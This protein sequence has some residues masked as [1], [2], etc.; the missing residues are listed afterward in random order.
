MTATKHMKNDR[1]SRWLFI[2]ETIGVGEVIRSTAPYLHERTKQ[3]CY[4]ELTS[5]G[6]III[7]GEN[8]LVITC[9][10][11][12]IE[13]VKAFY[14]NGRVPLALEG[15]VRTNIKR[16]YKEMQEVATF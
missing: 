6:V 14:P 7:K 1:M 3:L 12:T 15:R 5:T 13:Q 16:G 4:K 2:N 10:I 9:Y 11:A 8:A